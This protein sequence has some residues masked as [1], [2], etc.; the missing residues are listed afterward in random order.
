MINE[1]VLEK[2]HRFNKFGSR[3]GLERMRKLMT[4][5]GNPQD[6]MKVIH[7][8]GTNGKGSV[9]R[10]IYSV[11]QESGY[12]A[13]LYTSPYLQK[14]TERIEFDG[15][16]IS[17]EALT[18]I[19]DIVFEKAEHMITEGFES[20]TEFEIVTAMAFL[21]F[22]K[23]DMDYLV[24]EVG[25]GGR[26]DSTNIIKSSLVSIITSVSFDHTEQLGD[27][28]EKIAYEKAGIVKENGNVVSAVKDT[29]AAAA[30]RNVCAERKA[31]LLEM[32]H[33]KINNVKT[34][35]DQYEFDFEIL[36][37]LYKN[38]KISMIGMHQVENA[39]CALSAI[40]VLRQK[41]YILLSDEAVYRGMLKARQT[42]R[43]EI[44][45]QRPAIIIDGAHNEDGL[46]ALR[47][48]VLKHFGGKRRILVAGF[49]KDKKIENLAEHI[50]AIADEI[51]ATEPDSERKLD[52]CMLCNMLRSHGLSCVDMPD[53]IEAAKCACEM[54]DADDVIIFAGSLYLIGKI[55]SFFGR[56]AAG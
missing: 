5:L 22:S 33:G 6:D 2:I 31:C 48:T 3:L 34:G 13:G 54:A 21:Y 28:L 16:L 37:K 18:E 4:L 23:V 50:S 7:V 32:P 52:S 20:P 12:K 8:A 44:L 10:Y 11:L 17:M 24:L 43:F 40:Q 14:F 47:Q 42:G 35:I 45:S 39:A 1:G 51:I 38:V 15:R 55:R 25:L 46:K 19:A 29:R 41:H 30:I 49:L 26:G 56:E 36:G 27:T 53:C 9:S